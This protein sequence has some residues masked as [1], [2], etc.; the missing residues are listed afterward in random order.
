M[1]FPKFQTLVS[2][3]GGVVLT[4]GQDISSSLSVI[5]VIVRKKRQPLTHLT[6]LAVFFFNGGRKSCVW[7]L[8]FCQDDYFDQTNSFF[9]QTTK[10]QVKCIVSRVLAANKGL[11]LVCETTR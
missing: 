5:A 2:F 1:S 7:V 11:P 8:F 3:K 9:C 6:L 10:N 4:K